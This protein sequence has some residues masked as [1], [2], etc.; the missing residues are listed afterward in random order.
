M[1]YKDKP[2]NDF[3]LPEDEFGLTDDNADNIELPEIDL[4][5]DDEALSDDTED[6]DEL[7]NSLVAS[8]GQQ[9]N[10]ELSMTDEGEASS[11]DGEDT[12]MRKAKKKKKHTVLKVV[13]G[14]LLLLILF[15]CTETGR[16][17]LIY[18][19]IGWWIQ[20]QTDSSTTPTPTPQIT[21]QPNIS[22]S[23]VPTIEA[24]VPIEP[25]HRTEDYVTNYLLVGIEKI[26]GANTDSMMVVSVNT[27]DDSI[28]LTSL[29]RDTL[30]AM[31]G[32]EKRCKLNAV[33]AY[34]DM[35]TLIQVIEDTYDIEIEGYAS[36]DFE[37]FES[38]VDKIGGVDIE[39]GS[40]EAAYLRKEN[41]I[42]KPENRTV[43]Q[44]WNH[45]NGNQALGYCRVRHVATLGGAN[46]DY[47]RTVRQ[48][49][50]ISAVLNKL[51]EKSLFDLIS[52]MSD[53]LGYVKTNLSS[54]QISDVIADVIENGAFTIDTSRLP[55]D[56]LFYDSGKK[57]LEGITYALVIDDYREENIKKFHQFIFLDPEPTE[58]ATTTPAPE[59]TP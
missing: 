20:K 2:D 49:R 29:L 47:G 42:S 17:C 19:P 53:C 14:I 24:I 5:F 33:Y 55:M 13:L 36:V 9:V 12:D 50:L 28:K 23:P 52:L 35:E 43:V 32:R 40:T 18:N 22:T 7:M 56:N 30:V 25:E 45:L 38:I 16:R 27:K 3:E 10:E 37:S 34:S 54:S 26:F 1:S 57:G 4:D 8:L 46:N 41:Y 31:P 21:E 59:A 58:V 48:R 51:K 11:N 6:D 39:L 15:L 44:G